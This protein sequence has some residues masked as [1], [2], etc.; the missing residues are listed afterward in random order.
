MG[1]RHH[2]DIATSAIGKTDT[3]PVSVDPVMVKHPVPFKDGYPTDDS[4]YNT[5]T[6]FLIKAK[7]ADGMELDIRHDGDN[8]ILFEGMTGNLL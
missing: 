6:E 4:H 1:G 5:A 3:G 2:V 7:Y 8:G